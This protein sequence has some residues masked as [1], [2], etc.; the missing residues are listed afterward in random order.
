M[1]HK[2]SSNVVESFQVKIPVAQLDLPIS[3]SFIQYQNFVTHDS[4]YGL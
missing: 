1:L 2:I 4:I 3:D